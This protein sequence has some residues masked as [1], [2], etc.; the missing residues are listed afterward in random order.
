MKSFT[1]KGLILG[2][3][4]GLITTLFDGLYMLTPNVYVPF[5]YP[6]LLLAFNCLLWMLAGGLSG[7]FIRLFSHKKNDIGEK[8]NLYW[9]V[10]FLSPFVMIYGCMGRLFIP[11]NVKMITF[12]PQVFDHHFSFVWAS[13]ILIFLF[14]Y[15][16]KPGN[17]KNFSPVF[18]AF[19]I[20]AFIL[21]FQFCSNLEQ[22]KVPGLYTEYQSLFRLIKLERDYFLIIVY[23]SGVLSVSGFYF[24]SCFKARPYL[25]KK[26]AGR[27]YLL[28]GLLFIFVLIYLA[29]I[30]SYKLKSNIRESPLPLSSG[31]HSDQ[32]K[33][34]HV[35][36]IVL[37]TVRADRLSVYAKTGVGKNLYQFSKA[38]L[39]FE[40]CVA[41]SSWTIPSHAS[42]FTGLYPTEHGAHHNPNGK[43][44]SDSFFPAYPL[45]DKFVTLAEIFRYRGY[46]TSAVVSNLFLLNPAVNLDQGFQISDNSKN[47][48]Q[49]YKKYPF[50]PVFHLFCY[51][52]NF[53]PKYILPYRTADEITS[54]SINLIEKLAP[55]PFFHFI[56]YMD[57]HEPYRPPRPFNGY[58]FNSAFPQLYRLLHSYLFYTSD[59]DKKRLVPYLLS[60]YDGEIAYMDQELGRLFSR[61]KEIGIYDSSLIIITSDHGDLFGEHGLYEH[62]TYM[63]EGVIKVP[64]MIKY[65][66]SKKPGREKKIITLSDLYSTILSICELPVPDG[67]SGKA[68]GDDSTPA[69]SELYNFHTGKHQVLYDG[70]YKY[71]SYERNRRPELY[72]IKNDPLEEND[73][74]AKMA[75]VTLKMDK[76]LKKWVKSH[77]PKYTSSK[78]QKVRV[79]EETLESL[80][81]LGYIR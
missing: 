37:D 14:F 30:Y 46:K 59:A 76:T 15:F 42:L 23:M 40:N 67:I 64:L 33:V 43:T 20:A 70:K 72:D 56:N 34:P 36:L 8:E 35:I 38:S 29:G 50:A 10:F 79:P 51:I 41:T 13:L 61:L 44:E 39:V 81:S 62:D 60:Q 11:L 71:M 16:N 63:Y 54:Q 22:M 4:A 3:T 24:F 9:S 77:M 5:R 69:V 58:F 25:V 55:D 80:K 45:S 2:F 73:L 31:K 65:P 53:C 7:F 75:E 19:E 1:V 27:P 48:G 21:F 28:T 49:V 32:I 66:Y 78:K 18:F 52:T 6:F 74:A 17:R 57:A 68:F 12:R 47:M 26:F